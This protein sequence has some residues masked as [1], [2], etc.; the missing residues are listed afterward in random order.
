MCLLTVSNYL[1]LTYI[2]QLAQGLL[3]HLQLSELLD[4]VTGDIVLYMSGCHC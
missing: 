4:S 1:A 2:T 3:K